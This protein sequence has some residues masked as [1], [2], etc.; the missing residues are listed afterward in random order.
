MFDYV[1]FFRQKLLYI[2]ASPYLC[3]T[4]PQSYRETISRAIVLSKVPEQNVTFILFIYLFLLFRAAQG[5]YG[6]SQAK[7]ESELQ[8][9]VYTIATAMPEPSRICDLHYSSRQCW[10]L[11]PLS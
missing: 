6:G 8:L 2:L 7:V 9:P 11:N 1:L 10:I 3:G 4:A 5:A